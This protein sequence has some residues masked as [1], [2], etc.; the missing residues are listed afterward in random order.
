MRWS[1]I[2]ML[3]ALFGFGGGCHSTPS[4]NHASN[5][6]GSGNGSGPSGGMS[7]EVYRVRRER[8]VS[9]QIE[10]RGITDPRVLAAMRKVSRHL[11]IPEAERELAYDDGPVPIG[12]G[13]T[14]SQPYIVALMTELIRPQPGDRVLEVGTGSG[15]QAAVLAELAAEVYTIEILE[16][17]ALRAASLLRDLGYANVHTRIG[18]G[19]R[20]WPEKAPFDAII[21]TAAPGRVPE[22]L[23]QQLAPGGRLVIPVGTAYQELVLITRTA[24]GFREEAVTPVRFVPM[25]GEAE[26]NR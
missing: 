20:G 23:K 6:G 19:Y 4:G 1:V 14:I 22:P 25:T 13:Q 18:D 3:A 2:L 10:A 24:S 7:E 16:P 8:M 9:T 26:K 21:V 5:G 12:E 11:F 17:L 15:Y